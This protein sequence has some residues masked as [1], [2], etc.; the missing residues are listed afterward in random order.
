MKMAHIKKCDVPECGYNVEAHCHA[1]SITVGSGTDHKCDTFFN[2]PQK[3]GNPTACG[4]VGACKVISCTHNAR[5]EC[6]A[7]SIYIGQ[8]AGEVDCLSFAVG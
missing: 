5:L 6:S 7:D 2:F 1:M 8:I 4:M 3:G